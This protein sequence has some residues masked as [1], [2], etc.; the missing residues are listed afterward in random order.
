MP[1]GDVDDVQARIE[2]ARLLVQRAEVDER[3]RISVSSDDNMRVAV[4]V[5]FTG[6]T[7]DSPAF[8]A[9]YDYAFGDTEESE[10]YKAAY[11]EA[12][13]DGFVDDGG[14]SVDDGGASVETP[15]LPVPPSLDG[16]DSPL[17]GLSR[18]NVWYFTALIAPPVAVLRECG[19]TIDVAENLVLCVFGW[20][21]GVLHAW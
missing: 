15:I 13:H 3:T 7:D 10:E 12:F 5:D 14:V 11:A 6:D 17:D 18:P 19:C 21:P 1:S 4:W 20:L 9:A 2:K 16:R 8:R